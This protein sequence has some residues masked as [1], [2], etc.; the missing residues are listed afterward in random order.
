MDENVAGN[1][2]LE[3]QSFMHDMAEGIHEPECEHH[4]N[5]DD[6]SQMFQAESDI[7]LLQG[8]SL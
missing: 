4:E 2:K 1:D 6:D 5:E 3:D 7:P 8:V